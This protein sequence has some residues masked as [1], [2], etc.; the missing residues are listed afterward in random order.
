MLHDF[1]FRSVT[2]F[3]LLFVNGI[4]S[5]SRFI[6][7]HVK[8]QLFQHHLLK[9]CLF[10]VLL[11]LLLG[12]RSLCVGHLCGCI[13]GSP[14]CFHVSAILPRPRCLSSCGFTVSLEVEQRPSPSFIPL[15]RCR[16]DCSGSFTSL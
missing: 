16:V 1:P 6:F 14:F 9:D 15:L 2:L 3:E 7:L 13:S 8:I 11:P 12:Q 4:S 5:V 10:S